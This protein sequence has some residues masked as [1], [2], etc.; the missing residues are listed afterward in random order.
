MRVIRHVFEVLIS[1]EHEA[2]CRGS[3][4]FAKDRLVKA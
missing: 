3:E 2:E 4:A 1:P